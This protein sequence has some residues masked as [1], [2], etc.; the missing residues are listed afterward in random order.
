MYWAGGFFAYYEGHA[1]AGATQ[2]GSRFVLAEGEQGGAGRAQMFVLIANTGAEPAAVVVRTLGDDVEPPVTTGVLTIAGHARLT[3]PMASLPGYARGSIE[4]VE[5][6]TP[7]GALIVEGA[8]YSDAGG[9]PF[10]AGA[11]WPATRLSP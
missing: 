3:V 7:S 9:V 11:S 4:V 6:G 5:Q 2:T 8:L 1:S 10:A